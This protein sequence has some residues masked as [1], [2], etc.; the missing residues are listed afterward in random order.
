MAKILFLILLILCSNLTAGTTHPSKKDEK[1]LEYGKQYKHVVELNC[2]KAEGEQL[3][4]AS[5]VIISPNWALTAAHVVKDMNIAVII[6][7]KKEYNINKIIWHK[8][9]KEE[10]FGTNDIALLYTKDDFKMDFYL[11]LYKQSDEIGSLAAIAGYGMTGDFNTGAIRYDG[12]IRAGTN[13]VERITENI[14]VCSASIN[15]PSVLEFLTASGDSGGGLF[16]NGKLAGI[17]SIVFS[18]NK[19][20]TNS[21]YG[22]Y[23]GHTR[24]SKY[25]DWIKEKMENKNEDEIQSVSK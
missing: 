20:K 21:I 9:F 12:R 24:I 8:D 15:N 10:V 14:I 3:Y 4:L 2:R 16:I 18:E 1:Y 25:V 11:E 23:S 22:N 13:E 6:K 5:A 19:S 17:N 7:N